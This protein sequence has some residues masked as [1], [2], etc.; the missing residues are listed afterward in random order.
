MMPDCT[1]SVH[2]YVCMYACM[3]LYRASLYSDALGTAEDHQLSSHSRAKERQTLCML[4]EQFIRS[5]YLSV[6][7]TDRYSESL[8][9]PRC[10]EHTHKVAS[11]SNKTASV[12]RQKMVA[13]NA[14]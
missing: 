10:D 3:Y 6:K 8:D 11:S 4:A 5:T 7:G 9:V 12:V 14:K 13:I 2:Q 1:I